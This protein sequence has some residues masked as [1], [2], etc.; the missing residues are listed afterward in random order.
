MEII[1]KEP[2]D[3]PQYLVYTNGNVKS[4]RTGKMLLPHK[5]NTGYHNVVLFDEKSKRR[6]VGV[7]RLVGECHIDNPENKP[8]VD[9]IDRNPSNNDIS[10]L[11]WA[12]HSENFQNKSKYK[13]NN[14]GHKNIHYHK[15]TNTWV[16]SKT[17]NKVLFYKRFQTIEEAIEFK[18]K[19]Q[20]ENNII[21]V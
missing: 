17:I 9:H 19:Y 7:H 15:I 16:Y 13:T 12:T 4:K 14:S 21:C 11:R 6:C 10:N 18:K 20:E 8:H 5:G 3:F 2:L 1:P